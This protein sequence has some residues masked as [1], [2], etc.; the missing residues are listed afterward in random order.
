MS[1]LDPVTG[2]R[3]CLTLLHSLWQSAAVALLAWVVGRCTGRKRVNSSYVA[4]VLAM[5][6][7]LIAVPVTYL[8]LSV[9]QN[10]PVADLSMSKPVVA[11]ATIEP[12]S[13]PEIFSGEWSHASR[14]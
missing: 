3:I 6:L 13:L 4:S 7:G 1:V 9:D 11:P 2:E 12:V 14:L 8:M 5:I 10:E